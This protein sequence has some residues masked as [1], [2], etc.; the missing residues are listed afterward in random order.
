MCL[1]GTEAV[2]P[3]DA[4]VQQAGE[5]LAVGSGSQTYPEEL[6]ALAGVSCLDAEREDYPRA[7]ALLALAGF[8]WDN[9]NLLSAEQAQPVYLRDNVAKKPKLNVP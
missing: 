7:A 1:Q 8:D 6:S 9:K 3:V 5:W 2:S 4:I